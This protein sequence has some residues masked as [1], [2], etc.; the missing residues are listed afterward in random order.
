M[1]R[2][3][4]SER[5]AG[6]EEERERGERMRGGLADRSGVD[7]LQTIGYSMQLFAQAKVVEYSCP[8]LKL[9]TASSL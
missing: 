6:R 2:G 7:T 8:T 5:G 1:R 4:E 3:A 9:Q